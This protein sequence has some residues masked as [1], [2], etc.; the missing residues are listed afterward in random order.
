MKIIY[1]E[2]AL[3]ELERFQKRRKEELES[4]LKNRKYVFGDDVLEITASDIRDVERHFKVADLSKSKLPLTNMVL[5]LY[6]IM[7]VLMVLVGLFYPDLK[8]LLDRNP[9]QLALVLTG[10]GLSMASFFG[11]YYFRTKE[12]RRAEL[13]RRYME[14]ESKSKSGSDQDS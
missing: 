11:S 13:E 8:Q 12:N 2:S 1:T 10:L 6:M 9:I 7:G 14:F 5:K 4:L 3:V